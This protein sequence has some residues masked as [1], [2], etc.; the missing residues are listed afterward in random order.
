MFHLSRN[1]DYASLADSLIFGAGSHAAAA[2]NHIV[3]FVFFVRRLWISASSRQDVNPSAHGRNAEKLQVT[4]P[5]LLAAFLSVRDVEEAGLHYRR[6]PVALS[7]ARECSD[8][9]FAAFAS[10]RCCSADRNSSGLKP[11]GPGLLL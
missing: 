11:N 5:G 2:T 4:L 1:K 7:E 6:L 9:W 3:Q 10:G 8:S